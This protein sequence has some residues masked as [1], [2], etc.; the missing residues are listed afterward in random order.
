MVGLWA[1]LVILHNYRLSLNSSANESG[2]LQILAYEWSKQWTMWDE[3]QQCMLIRLTLYVSHITIPLGGWIK[4]L[5]EQCQR[6]SINTAWFTWLDLCLLLHT[7]M[8]SV[9]MHTSV[10]VHLSLTNA[11]LLMHHQNK[12]M[13]TEII[14][15]ILSN[16]THQYKKHQFVMLRLPR[17]TW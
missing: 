11:C 13:N 14:K 7:K 1:Q 2:L 16:P 6:L 9:C 3:Q 8:L 17:K 12:H 5:R 4:G 15:K 10:C